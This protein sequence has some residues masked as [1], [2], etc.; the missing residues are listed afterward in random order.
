MPDGRIEIL[1]TRRVATTACITLANAARAMDKDLIEATF[2][3]L[4]WSFVPQ[5]P[6]AKNTGRVSRGFEHLRERGRFEAH[7]LAFENRVRDAGT[8]LVAP[9]HERTARGSTGRP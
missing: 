8:E 6:L 4:V 1:V 2:V 5:V 9:G 7:P 3:G